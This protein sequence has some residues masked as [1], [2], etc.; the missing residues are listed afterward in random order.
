MK[1]YFQLFSPTLHKY[2]FKCISYNRHQDGDC[3]IYAKKVGNR[4]VEVQVYSN[5]GHR[6]SHMTHHKDNPNRQRSKLPP[7]EFND[8]E[9]MIEAI[10][11]EY[12]RPD[13]FDEYLNDKDI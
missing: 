13:P 2:G 5:G 4:T 11:Y 8:I 10:E 9:S 3:R 1:S 6:A 7:T 12:I